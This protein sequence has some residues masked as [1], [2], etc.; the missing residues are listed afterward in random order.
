VLT[1]FLVKF[2]TSLKWKE[3]FTDVAAQFD[4][5]KS[6][7][8]FDL[9]MYVG[10][11]VAN[12]K[13]TLAVVHQDVSE[14]MTLVF[15]NM[16]SPEEQ[17]FAALVASSGGAKKVFANDALLSEVLDKFKLR[18][19]KQDSDDAELS[20]SSLR[21]EVAKNP[22]EVVMEDAK[23]FDQRFDAVVVQLEEEAKLQPKP[24]T[25]STIDERLAEVEA[26]LATAVEDRLARVEAKLDERA[27]E[28]AGFVGDIAVLNARV[29]KLEALLTQLVGARMATS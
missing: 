26:K 23:A 12:V 18:S 8:Q 25:L 28:H 10:T 2:F 3:K 24:P 15:E 7:L 19:D 5:H 14:M 9:Q 6:E 29:G 21:E 11:T 4:V 16:R 13:A 27:I 22:D 17:D 20:P 1:L